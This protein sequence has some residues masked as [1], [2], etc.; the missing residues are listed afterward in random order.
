MAERRLAVIT[1][2]VSQDLWEAADFARANGL[3]GL[4]LRSI[5]GRGPFE[6]IKADIEAVDRVRAVYGLEICCL[7]LPFFK[8]GVSDGAAVESHLE[9]L[10]RA[11]ELAVRW[12]AP[13]VR[14]FAFWKGSGGWDEAL[15]RYGRV[16]PLLREAGVTLALET[17][18]AVMTTNAGLL[19]RFLDGLDAPEVMALWDPGNLPFDPEGEHPYPE[20]YGLLRGRIAHVHLKD[21]V[22]KGADARAVCLGEGLVDFPG[23][24]AALERDG[25]RGYLSLETHYRLGEALTEE[26]MRLPGGYQFSKGGRAASQECMDAMKKWR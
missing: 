21:A 11:L 25:Y 2:E 10:R 22:G 26:E 4:E 12:Q 5:N 9:G 3:S 17:E 6:W 18:P 7:A 24:L 16:L 19:R 1:D 20:G 23:Q 14:G 8:C 15:E 13:V